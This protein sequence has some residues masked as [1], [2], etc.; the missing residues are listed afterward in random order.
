MIVWIDA[1]TADS[2]LPVFGLS[3]LERHLHG[4]RALKPAPA[5]V[6]IDL[7]PGASEPKLGDKRLYRLPLEWQRDGE[8]Y[9][10]R[11]GRIL[12]AAGTD[13]VLVLDAATLADA[14]LP[15]VLAAR[16][17]S[18][19]VFSRE[20]QDRAAI[21]FLAGDH[22]P[23]TAELT[24]K[25]DSTAALA[26]RLVQSGRV[27]AFKD[28]EFNGFVRRLRRTLPYYLFTVDGPARAAKLERFLFWSNYK[29]S[30]DLFTRYVYPPLVWLAVRPLARWRVHPNWVTLLSII[31]AL[32]A[33]PF[34]ANG[35]FITGFVMAFGMSV[36]DSVDGKLARVTF[37]DSV[38]GNYLDHG[39]DMV[40]PPLWY[41]SWA[42]GLGI[43]LE[44]WWSPL[45]QGAIAIFALYVID[46][47]VLKIYP[48]VFKRA[49]HT[50]SRLD[51]T[52]R[53]F[54]ARRNISLPLFTVG[55]LIGLGR[56]AFFLIVA[57][58]AATTLY[59]ASRTF[60]ILC[61]EKAQ[62]KDRA[63]VEMAAKRVKLD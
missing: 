2:A 28:E 37:T 49:F 52:V 20:A 50:H 7:A 17:T 23:V 22:A 53:S 38:L 51:G 45:G 29:G 19:V 21:L 33:I 47:L 26:K 56:E 16:S 35:Y 59:H 63:P 1:V 42:Y 39:L 9:A 24:G 3:L 25:P 8:P 40:H 57:W 61:I 58:Q 34:W 55:Y 11:L 44:G 14:R 48:Y 10:A 32:A 36:L 5:R 30:T 31:L 4:L 13:P 41:F 60:W 43:A 18:T 27:A 12:A 62:R 46:R 6:V 54:I 15:A